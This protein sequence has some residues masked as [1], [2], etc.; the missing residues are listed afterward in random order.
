LQKT[1]YGCEVV[2][3]YRL[4][5]GQGEELSLAR[6]KAEMMGASKLWSKGPRRIRARF[7]SSDVVRANASTEGLYLWCTSIGSAVDFLKLG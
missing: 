5:F 1:E 4:I 7:S 2:T 6:A 3:L